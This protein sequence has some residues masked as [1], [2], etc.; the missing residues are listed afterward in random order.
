MDIQTLI[1]FVDIA[2]QHS[3]S[4]AA[5]SQN[6][7]QS[8]LSKA[9]MRLENELNVHLFDRKKH[10]IELTPAG[11]CF[12]EDV[13]KMLP[14]YYH[15]I[16]RLKAFTSKCKVTVCVV[17]NDPRQNLPYAMQTFRD[18]NPNIYVE[19]LTQRDFSI[20]ERCLLNGEIDYLIAHD[21]LHEQEQIEKLAA[22]QATMVLFLSTSLTEQLQKDL[23][24]GGYAETTPAA[25]VYKATWRDQKIFRCTVGTLH[26]TVTQ[27]GL[28]K[29]S[30]IVVGGCLGGEYMRSLLYHPGFS[31]EFREASE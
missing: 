7:S 10:P 1:Y 11:E 24:A 8:S 31:T 28:T 2:E 19:F 29:T 23:L 20:A 5:E 22:H 25:V 14:N 9:I 26:K 17:P 6:I 16:R 12:Y 21:P 15:A 18:E 13:K 30:L 3:F 27:N 4:A